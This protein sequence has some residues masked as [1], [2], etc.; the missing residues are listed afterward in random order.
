MKQMY[1]ALTNRAFIEP[2]ALEFVKVGEFMDRETAVRRTHECVGRMIT[3]HSVYTE[4]QIQALI[5]NAKGVQD[6][7]VLPRQSREEREV[8]DTTTIE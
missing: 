6:L 5:N 1:Y 4:E 2:V 7:K 8:E 3:V